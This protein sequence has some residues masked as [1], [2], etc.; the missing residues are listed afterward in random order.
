MEN[1][2]AQSYKIAQRKVNETESQADGFI[3]RV[4]KMDIIPDGSTKKGE[5]YLVGFEVTGSYE[6]TAN[7]PKFSLK[8]L[9]QYKIFPDIAELVGHG[10]QY[11]GYTPV[12]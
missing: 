1:Y 11:D 6:G 8:T 12:I 3:R 9:F 4:A 10:G 7:D 2:I 5:S